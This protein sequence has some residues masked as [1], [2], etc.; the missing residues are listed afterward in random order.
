MSVEFTAGVLIANLL[1][2][3]KFGLGPTIALRKDSIGKIGGYSAVRE[4][5]SNDFVVGNF[6]YKAGFRVVLSS[7]V[8]DHVSPRDDVPAN[9][10][11]AAALGHGHSLLASERPLRDGA[12]LRGPLWNS[13]ADRRVA[14]WATRG[15]GVGLLAA[16]LL[17]RMAECWIVGWSAAH[18]PVARRLGA[19]LSAAGS[20]RLY[21]LV[22]QLPVQTQPVA[23]QQLRVAQRWQARRPAGQWLDRP[24]WV[25]GS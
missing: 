11:T 20:A 5:L 3:M 1:E 10:G 18:D 7:H 14:C 8:V 2:G 6:I 13:R 22:R 19:A 23:R 15:W 21:N 4:Y 25:V 9:V 17:N 16:S 24:A 12:D